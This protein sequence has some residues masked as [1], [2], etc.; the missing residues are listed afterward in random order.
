[1]PNW[2]RKLKPVATT[3]G[4]N[5]NAAHATV[6]AVTAVNVAL[7]VAIVHRVRKAKNPKHSQPMPHLVTTTSA[8]RTHT[9]TQQLR[10]P[11]HRQR[12]RAAA[13]RACKP[14]PWCCLT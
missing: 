1:M 14:S 8:Q 12:M 11:P 2:R 6:M 9:V 3:M 10:T 5:A 13:C 7:S 4:V